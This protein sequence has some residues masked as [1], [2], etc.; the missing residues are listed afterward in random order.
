MAHHQF[1]E[2][3]VEKLALKIRKGGC[4]IDVKCEFDR[5]ALAAA[6]FSGWRL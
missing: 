5:K 6:G 1:K 3:G 2:M 4:F